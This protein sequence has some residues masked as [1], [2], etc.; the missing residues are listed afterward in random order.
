MNRIAIVACA[1]VIL[2]TIR[3]ATLCYAAALAQLIYRRD[4]RP[5]WTLGCL[6]YLA[7]VLAAFHFA[8]HWSHAFAVAETA[9]Q[10]QALFGLNWGGGV[11]FNYVF[12]ALW[13]ADT[14]WWWCS[15]QTRASR[16]LLLSRSIHFYLA[17]MFINGAIVFPQGL[18]RWVSLALAAALVLAAK[19]AKL[20]SNA[21]R[22]HRQPH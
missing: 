5:L 13:T 22:E 6:L 8:Y 17:W 20:N 7:H 9:R 12:T 21:S 14:L 19:H 3:L 18:T 16:P 15:P 11:W 1:N 2:W 4:A 10:T